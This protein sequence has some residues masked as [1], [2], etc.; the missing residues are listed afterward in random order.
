MT[1]QTL[2][3]EP[4]YN[5]GML[6]IERLHPFDSRKFGRAFAQVSDT[7][8]KA[9][10][11]ACWLRPEG[12][13][14]TRAL[15]TVHE[16]E[17]LDALGSATVVAQ[18]LEV[19]ALRFLGAHLLRHGVLKPMLRASAGT[20]LAAKRAMAHGG[21][22]INLGGGFH[23]A[24]PGSGEGFCVYADVGIAIRTL[25]QEGVL[26]PGARVVHIDLDAH[27]GN[28]VAHVFMEEPEVTLFDM[29]NEDNYPHDPPARRR[30]DHPIPL[31]PMTRG[32]LYLETLKRE[33]PVFLD[34]G[35]SPALAFYN[36]GTDIL[37][38]DP[39][40][41]LAVESEAILERDR[42]VIDAL[43]QRSIPWV[44]VTSGGYTQASAG[45]IAQTVID[46]LTV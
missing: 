17:Y 46:A 4:R 21:G 19:P 45:L 44:M 11:E 28:G 22:A 16:K 30:L 8:P 20:V 14:D 38:G 1:I 42:W 12:M 33:L 43:D 39:L 3:Y 18:V 10:L 37:V 7:V 5:I 26:Q 27:M 23:H 25:Q 40:G 24:K 6:G 2:V 34:T 41:G 35:P 36:A 13:L 31:A 15:Q 32:G 9:V 29:F